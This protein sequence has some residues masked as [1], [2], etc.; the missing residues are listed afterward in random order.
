MLET[1][2]NLPKSTLK[3]VLVDMNDSWYCISVSAYLKVHKVDVPL[4]LTYTRMKLTDEMKWVVA[5]W[6]G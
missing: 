6:Q 4:L 3:L 5:V 2:G 1:D